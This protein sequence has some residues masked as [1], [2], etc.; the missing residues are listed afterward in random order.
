[1]APIS[2]AIKSKSGNEPKE[3]GRWPSEVTGR[4]GFISFNVTRVTRL[5]SY[6]HLFP[7]LGAPE[8]VLGI[9]EEGLGLSR[10][11]GKP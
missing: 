5:Q 8:Q 2:A 3:R 7:P 1:M 11:S 4:A 10:L 9:P 6:K